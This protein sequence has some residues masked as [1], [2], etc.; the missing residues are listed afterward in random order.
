ME[1]REI[2]RIIRN[3]VNLSSRTEATAWV[4]YN[5]GHG[6]FLVLL[7]NLRPST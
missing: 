2:C 7:T 4:W 5:K 1:A 3:D 6:L